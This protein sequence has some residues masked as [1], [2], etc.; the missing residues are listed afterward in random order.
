VEMQ[1]FFSLLSSDN[2][3]VSNFIFHFYYVYNVV[4]NFVAPHQK[5]IKK[6][7]RFNFS[8]KKQIDIISLALNAFSHWPFDS[9]AFF[10][11]APTEEQKMTIYAMNLHINIMN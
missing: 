4:A 11:V 8:T 7:F 10:V 1:H 6:S 2:E 9:N 3:K 5:H